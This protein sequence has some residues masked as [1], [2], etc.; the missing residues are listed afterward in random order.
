MAPSPPPA[1]GHRTA[2]QVSL[3]DA[4]A[5]EAGGLVQRVVVG[6]PGSALYCLGWCPA[7]QGLLGAAGSERSLQL[8]EP[9]K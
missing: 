3:W 2:V 9:R 8:I 5:G 7:Q 1:L 4:R 6:A